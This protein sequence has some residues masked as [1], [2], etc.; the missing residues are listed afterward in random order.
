MKPQGGAQGVGLAAVPGPA[1]LGSAHAHDGPSVAGVMT[2]V[3]YQLDLN[4]CDSPDIG[5]QIRMGCL[6]PPLPANE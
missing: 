5:L 3:S 1:C 2:F 4:P 6:E